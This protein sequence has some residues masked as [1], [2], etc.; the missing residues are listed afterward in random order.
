MINTVRAAIAINS[1]PTYALRQQHSAVGQALS[2][3]GQDQHLTPFLSRLP[4]S[5]IQ[6]VRHTGDDDAIE[7]WDRMG[8]GDLTNWTEACI[9]MT[10]QHFAWSVVRHCHT[11]AG[12]DLKRGQ[13]QGEQP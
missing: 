10:C 5:P 12:Y 1:L 11:I 8:D 3:R 13:P 4:S 6:L 2:H 7:Q 9:F